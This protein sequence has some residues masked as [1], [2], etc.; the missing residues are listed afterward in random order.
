MEKCFCGKKATHYVK[1][2]G[3]EWHKF[4]N[5]PRCEACKDMA[6]RSHPE[7]EVTELDEKRG[8]GV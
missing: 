4:S 2:V 8:V 1:V 7:V 3:N 5:C 6:V